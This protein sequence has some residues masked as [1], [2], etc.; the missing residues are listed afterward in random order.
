M[1]DEEE[2]FRSV[3]SRLTGEK[4]ERLSLAARALR[5]FHA[6]CDDYFRAILPHDLVLLGAPSGLGKTQTA[7]SIAM[8]NAAGG[9]RV[10]YFALE[11]ERNEL[12]RRAK[13]S[14]LALEARRR[15]RDNAK[16][17]EESGR[18]DRIRDATLKVQA[19]ESMD[20]AD[21]L[22]GK[23]EDICGP[24]N[25]A[26]DRKLGSSMS[27]MYTFYRGRDFTGADL[28]KRVAEIHHDTD[29]IVVDHLHYVDAADT[30][31]EN[32]AVTDLIKMIRDIGLVIGKPFLLVAHLR[33]RNELAHRV[34]P[35][36]DDFHGSS[37]LSKIVTQAIVLERAH[38]IESPAWYLAPTF[39]AVR[40][41]RRSGA[42]PL[43]ALMYYNM[44][45][46]V[47]DERYT[48]GRVTGKQWK[49]LGPL[50]VPRWAKHHVQLTTPT[51][52]TRSGDR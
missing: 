13:F 41:D 6:L 8:S 9:R 12:E 30:E 11:A 14:M 26:V 2:G 16:D 32:R 51:Q 45:T 29:L 10:H 46:R 34:V 4:E 50:E 37:N 3:A 19:A 7:L 22:L 38:E 43:V 27:T 35:T 1:S 49:E 52:D 20:Y 47:Y 31:D 15:A 24:M 39:I 21:W 23:C 5:Y 33:K 28:A 44:I 36:L 42:T 48:L 17:A 18:S 40:K 25:A